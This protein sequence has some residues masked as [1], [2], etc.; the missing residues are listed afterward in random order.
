[1]RTDT[2]HAILLRDYRPPAFLIDTINLDVSLDPAATR[3]RSK[4]KMRHN[5]AAGG[6]GPLHLDGEGLQLEQIKLDGRLLTAADYTVTDTA[7]II[8]LVPAKPFALDITTVI[9]TIL[10]K[11]ERRLLARVASAVKLLSSLPAEGG[12]RTKI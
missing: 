6:H 12:A 11:R 4:L 5:P 9:T 3:V 7:L 8:P 1:M 10:R 2:P